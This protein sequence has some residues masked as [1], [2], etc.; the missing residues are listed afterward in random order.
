MIESFHDKEAERIF[1]R[2]FS[3]R[4]PPDIQRTALRRLLYLN[5]VKDL[6][7][8]STTPSLRPEPLSEDWEGQH[9]IRINEQWQVCFEWIDPDAHNVEIVGYP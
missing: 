6:R 4:L 9:S 8:L 2:S 1:N 5:A 3:R 7:D